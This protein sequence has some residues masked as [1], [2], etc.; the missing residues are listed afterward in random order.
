MKAVYI[1]NTLDLVL[2]VT[3]EPVEKGGWDFF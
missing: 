1:A 2:V 3:P